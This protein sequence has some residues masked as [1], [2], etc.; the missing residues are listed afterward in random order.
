MRTVPNPDVLVLW[1]PTTPSP[2]APTR[3]E[4][5]AAQADERA[6]A[7]ALAQLAV[8]R[9]RGVDPA[10]VVVGR[11]CLTCGSTAHGQPVTDGASVSLSHTR[12][13]VVAVASTAGPVGV[14][15]EPVTDTVFAGFDDVALA[16]DEARAL[17]PADATGRLRAW[18][19]KEA[20]LKACG[21]GLSIDPR[22]VVLASDGRV[23]DAPPQ[24][25]RPAV[26][27]LTF[28]TGAIGALAYPTGATVVVERVTR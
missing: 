9:V 3:A 11:R 25:G 2:A 22:H 16:P 17:A 24:V 23:I 7:G 6:S 20:V 27:D 10:D 19:R 28:E 14:D 13:L 21:W 15:A 1:S 8:A 5:R 26:G 4:R 12:G 18:V